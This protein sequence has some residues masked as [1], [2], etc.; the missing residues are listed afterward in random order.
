MTFYFNI[1][2]GTERDGTINRF[3]C[4]NCY[5]KGKYIEP[6]LTVDE[7]KKRLVTRLHELNYKKRKIRKAEKK[8]GGLLRWDRQRTW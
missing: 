8:I 2:R 6:E 1:E 4:I 7:V 5:D 3:F